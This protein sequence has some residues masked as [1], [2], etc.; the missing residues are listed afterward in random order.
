MLHRMCSMNSTGQVG[1]FL[2]GLSDI[3]LFKNHR[4]SQNMRRI[5]R[6][7]CQIWSGVMP[8][9][10]PEKILEIVNIFWQV[11]MKTELKEK[12]SHHVLWVR[13]E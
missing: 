3:E 6:Q 10:L 11:T 13:V 8:Q 9:K 12:I 2:R 5:R 7:I 4:K 1:N